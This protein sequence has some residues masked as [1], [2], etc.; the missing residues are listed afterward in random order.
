MADIT[1]PQ[2]VCPVC[3]FDR[4]HLAPGDALIA[5]RSFPRRWRRLFTAVI[6]QEEGGEALLHRPLGD[7]GSAARRL[8]HVIGVFQ[9][10]AQHLDRMWSQDDP[11]LDELGGDAGSD[12]LVTSPV[13]TLLDQMAAA[14]GRLAD[15]ID[16]YRGEQWGRTGHRG[17]DQVSALDLT[18]DAIHDAS[19]HLR[20]CRDDL[21]RVCG[22]PVDE[23]R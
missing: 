12:R 22:H 23:D 8:N 5:A 10:T 6:Q 7:G 21:A 11:A 18:R 16:R 14:A 19:H 20:V 1:R 17:G 9:G 15:A 2:G 3:G 4:E 13:S